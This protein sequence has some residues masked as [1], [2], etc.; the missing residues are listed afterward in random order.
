MPKF[1][2]VSDFQPTGDQ[3]TAIE[4]LVEGVGKGL[5]Y[6]TLLGATGTG[7]T[8][9][10][11][12]VIE[13]TQRPTLVLAHNKTLAAQLYAEFK[14]FFPRNAV[15]YY[16][17]YYDY[18]QP[19]SYVPRFDLFIEKQTEINEQIERLRIASK[20]AL[21]SRRDVLI[22]ASVSCIYGTGDPATWGNS[23]VEFR[24]GSSVKRETLLRELVRIQYTRSEM[25]LGKGN[26]RA[27]GDVLEVFPPYEDAAYR[28]T[29]FGDDVERI[30]QFDPLTG[31]LIAQHET[32]VV[33]PAA[34]FMA[35]QDKLKV[36]LNNIELELE[37]QVKFF[38]QQG[39]LLES[40][41]IQQRVN[42]DLEM[43]REMGFTSGIENYSRHLELR[44]PGSPPWTLLDYFPKDYL[45]IIDESH[46]TIPQIRGMY[47]GDRTRKET[48]VEYGFRLP[49]AMDNR[50]LKFDE[51]EARTNQIIFT[52]AT[53]GPY[54]AE[55]QQ[56]VVQQVIRPTGILDPVVV[57]RP[58]KGQIDDLL[59]EVAARVR[60]GQRALITTL[61]QRMSEELAGYINEIGIKAQY[62]HAEIQ[63]LERVEILRDLRLGVYDVIVGINLLREGIDLPEVSLVVILDADKEGFLRSAQALVQT[64][65]RA[66]RHVDGQ[67]ILYADRITDSMK[68]AIDETNRRRGV[69][70]AY[71][72]AHGITPTTIVKQVRDLTDRVKSMV[73]DE[74]KLPTGEVDLMTLP[75]QE[76]HKMI[77]EL[78]AEMKRAAKS[79][80]FEK[81]A[82]LRDQMLELKGIMASRDP[83]GDLEL[84]LS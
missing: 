54:E 51:F 67:V 6:Q 5:K 78:D 57:V 21:L 8:Y 66:A 84:V 14:E 50:P 49:S 76:L 68:Y 83:E 47:N 80:E 12:S 16:V 36:A 37:E 43:L 34:Q 72:E 30:V 71:N 42:Y 32:V 55:V 11:A 48:L 56:N 18:Y 53:P 25:D 23:I 58:T 65:G 28:I 41:R 15:E 70:N 81:A 9:A 75:K 19:E 63:T 62:I 13:R 27:R 24:A 35:D 44:P 17:S 46:M 45:M 39:K 38:N 20:A 10:A 64:I 7:K 2:L 59:Q 4:G 69:Q 40:Q 52:S 33:F 77:S 3:P 73:S 1:E 61:T 79:L 60:V 31:E 74:Q 22:V 82:M 29:L 26:F